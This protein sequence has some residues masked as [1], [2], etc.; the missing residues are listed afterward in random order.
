[1][2]TL[3]AGLASAKSM[4]GMAPARPPTLFEELDSATSLSWKKYSFSPA[5]M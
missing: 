2:E 5:F 4:L 1:M 3:G